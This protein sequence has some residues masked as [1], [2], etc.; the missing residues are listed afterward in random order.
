[1]TALAP[2]VRTLGRGPGRSR[3]LTYEEAFDAMRIIL[4]GQG[5]PEAIGA[6]LMLLRM[7]GEVPEEIA[8]FVA[9]ARATL[10]QITPPALDWP[11]YAAGRSRGLPFF[12]LSARLVARSGHTVLMHGWNSEHHMATSASVRQALP[13]AGI[14]TAPSVAEAGRLLGRDGIAYLPLESFQPGLLDLLR[15]R[16]KLGV[17]SCVNTVL[18]VL[19]P[20]HAAAS[21][22]GV[23]HPPYRDL[24]ADA[25][26]LLGQ[27]S[28]TVIK[29][30]G[31]EFERNPAK[32][33]ALFGLR[34]AAAFDGTAP[35]LLDETTRLNQGWSDP[36]LLAGLWSGDWHDPFAEAIVI[37][38]AELA[39]A[40]LGEPTPGATARRLWSDRAN[41]LADLRD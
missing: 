33:I 41:Q 15:L 30:G 39:L 19:N 36:A 34:D 8:G 10:P 23:F 21:V 20:A 32:S 26:K 14:A 40:T 2:H 31:G 35:A 7:K 13:F 18:R 12:L 5:D 9:A 16:D 25:G 24:Q 37:G 17:R 28:L 1:M 11:S 29:G 6:L 22:Q 38:T 27:N 3:S 4:D